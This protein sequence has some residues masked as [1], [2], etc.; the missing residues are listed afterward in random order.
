L[1]DGADTDEALIERAGR[2]DRLAASLL[3]SRHSDRLLR[4]AWRMLGERAAAEDVVQETFLKLWERAPAWRRQSGT[5]AGAP[6][7]WLVR[8]A[9]NGALD[10]L[11]R[12]G[13]E[14]EENKA[15]ERADGA[16]SA[17]SLMAAGERRSAVD[18]AIASLPERQRLAVTLCHLEEMGNIE[19]AAAMDVSV[20]ALES[21][22]SR[23]RRALKAALMDQR[24]ELM[25]GI[26]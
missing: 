9:S 1:A 17:L 20:E 14:V 18:S 22:L 12:R 10:R 15:P 11:R 6:S 3:V 2:G 24:D 4:V 19:A 23:A 21:L 5:F 26:A 25:E 7:A 16:Q 13:R 8:V